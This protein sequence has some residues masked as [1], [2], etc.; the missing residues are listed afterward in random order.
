MRAQS[1]LSE[2][3]DVQS[4]NADRPLD[5]I[6]KIS[7]LTASQVVECDILIVGGGTGGV[8]AALAASQAENGSI[9][10][11]MTEETDWIG[12]QMTSQAV[13]ALDENYLVEKSGACRNYQ[14][15]RTAI[16][17]FYRTSRKLAPS[18][19]AKQYLDPGNCWVSRLA[20]E[21]KIAVDVLRELLEPA[22]SA[23]RLATYLRFKPVYANL[24]T[25]ENGRKTIHSI[26]MLSLDS[27]E[28]IEF[29]ARLFIDA[30]ELGDLL[31]LCNIQYSSGSDAFDQ[32]QEPHA[33]VNGDAENVQD[34]VFPFVIEFRPGEQHVI[35]KPKFY[36]EFVAKEKFSLQSY[37]MFASSYR[38]QADGSEQELLPFWTYRRLID[39]TFFDDEHYPFDLSMINWDSNDLRRENIIDKSAEGQCER[40]AKAKFLSLGFLYWLQTEA[41]RD[42]G[43]IGYPELKLRKD[44]LATEDGLAK[45]PY[46]RESRR[47]QAIKKIV[48]Q[49]IVACSNPA[50]RAT[51]HGDS[52]GIGLYP[53]DIHGDQEVPGA[54]QQTA[55][56]QIP[57]AALIP[58]DATN[59]LPA[60]KNIGTT[61]ITNGAY[62]LHPIEWAIGEAQGTVA[63]DVIKSGR[64]PKDYVENV[65]LLR[66]IQSKLVENG[67]PT[68]W[69]DDVATDD[70]NFAAIQF[71]AVSDIFLGNDNDLHFRPTELLTEKEVHEV[72]KKLYPKDKFKSFE[73]N[74]TATMSYLQSVCESKPNR[75]QDSSGAQDE[76]LT[77]A[78]FAQ[79][80]FKLVQVDHL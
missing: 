5:S 51:L 39:K 35:T 33:P 15:V 46:I 47:I 75:F 38:K 78:K 24:D 70:E 58:Q 7:S 60:C 22:E 10:V 8:A 53:V 27:G 72:L 28:I 64:E 77:R 23:G 9:K 68:Y 69:Y 1:S 66:Q 21:P 26:G 55:P 3:V 44:V 79:H 17:D 20:F 36:H 57:L 63:V 48:E 49:D 71:L 62:R 59:L 13:S 45:Y 12:G 65:K 41:P 16:R 42:D 37:K 80:L 76:S 30:T 54:A 4:I 14:N 19:A 40:L 61:H 43:G 25:T 34:F 6:R 74:R 29:R 67:S 18:A 52:V 11:C 2:I 56:F 31:P 32:T 50:A 73:P